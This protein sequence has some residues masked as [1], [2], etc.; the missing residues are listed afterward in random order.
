MRFFL[1]V[2]LVPFIAA[3]LCLPAVAAARAPDAAIKTKTTDASVTIDP[4]LQT[5]NQ[6]R[7]TANLITIRFGKH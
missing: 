3:S 1:R 5:F 4:A 7:M 6:L 2:P